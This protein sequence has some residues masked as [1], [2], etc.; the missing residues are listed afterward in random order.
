MC[1]RVPSTVLL[2]A[3]DAPCIFVIEKYGGATGLVISGFHI[4]CF[5]LCTQLFHFFDELFEFMSSGG[6]GS[7]VCVGNSVMILL[8]SVKRLAVTVRTNEIASSCKYTPEP[9][10]DSAGKWLWINTSPI[11]LS[12]LQFHYSVSSL[13][14]AEEIVGKGN[15]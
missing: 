15:A 6:D 7:A 11:Y 3:F 1:H 4:T 14:G 2:L 10:A 5:C 8:C 12:R 13:Y 9:Q